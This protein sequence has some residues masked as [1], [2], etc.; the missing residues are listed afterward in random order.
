M[1]LQPDLN[2][3]STIKTLQLS[4]LYTFVSNNMAKKLNSAVKM[5]GLFRLEEPVIFWDHYTL[6]SV[7]RRSLEAHLVSLEIAR[8]T[9]NRCSKY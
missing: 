9:G 1:S 4:S 5:F 2:I 7:L 6:H 8:K 3:L